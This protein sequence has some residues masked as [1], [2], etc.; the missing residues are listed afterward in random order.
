[1][2]NVWTIRLDSNRGN[3]RA[4]NQDCWVNETVIVHGQEMLLFGVADGVGG[5][6]SGDVASR[7]AVG[8]LAQSVTSGPD[9][10]P[11][12]ALAHGFKEA[13]LRVYNESLAREECAGMGTTLT[14]ALLSGHKL[15]LGHV[16]DSRC[17]LYSEQGLVRLTHDHSLAEEL[18]RLGGLSP[19]DAKKHP[20]RH[21]LTRA[22]GIEPETAV[23]F[24]VVNLNETQKVLF[25][26]DGLTKL[27]N[28]QEIEEVLAS[29]LDR[30]LIVTRFMEMALERGAPDNVTVVLA[31]WEGGAQ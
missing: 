26:T 3:V 22:L 4:T 13:N 19:D 20:Q 1:V 25:C 27:V 17:Y 7:I 28:D 6:R 18:V 24:T 31:F 10:S 12:D 15:F 9:S 11:L 30:S 8:Q 5:H 2:E 29:N 23:D 14:A 16:G 21:M